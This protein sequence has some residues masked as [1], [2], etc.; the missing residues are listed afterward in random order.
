MM[1]KTSIKIFKQEIFIY[2][3]SSCQWYL[4]VFI[5]LGILLYGPP[6]TGKTL[7][8]RALAC[9][10]ETTFINL[11]SS[12]F[13]SKWRGESEKMI[14]VL[15]DVARYVHF[16][17]H[18]TSVDWESR[19]FRYYAPTTIFVDEVD[20]L[21]SRHDDNHHDAARRFKS[22]LLVQ[23]DGILGVNERI[24]ILAATNSPWY[25]LIKAQTL[26]MNGSF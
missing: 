5:P 22:E 20:A 2:N 7:L 15:F 25:V 16:K 12:S 8:A 4:L 13:V 3:N 11:T 17:E 1:V 6:G 18:I 14:K 24:V 19:N 23:L 10:T 9:E 21:A 26:F